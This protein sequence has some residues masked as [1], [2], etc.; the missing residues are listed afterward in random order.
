MFSLTMG[1]VMLVTSAVSRTMAAA[2]LPVT[3]ASRI[4]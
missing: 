2:L 4:R 3:A 1:R